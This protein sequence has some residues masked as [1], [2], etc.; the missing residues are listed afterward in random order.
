M[1]SA[2]KYDPALR[3]VMMPRDANV[4]GTIFG[5]VILSYIDQA[6]FIEARKHGLHRWVTVSIEQVEFRAPVLIGDAVSFY[7]S[8]ER[9]GTTSIKIRIHVEADRLSSGETVHV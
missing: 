1:G 2:P 5:G 7:T 9:I 4:Y 6:G 8:T 3:V